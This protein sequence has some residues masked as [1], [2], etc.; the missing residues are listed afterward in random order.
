MDTNS[1]SRL[2]P[3]VDFNCTSD[4]TSVLTVTGFNNYATTDFDLDDIVVGMIVEGLDTV[5]SV[6]SVDLGNNTITVSGNVASGTYQLNTKTA[7][8]MEDAANYTGTQVNL[9]FK[10]STSIQ[11]TAYSRLF[12]QAETGSSFIYEE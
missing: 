11:A 6:Q 7:I 12:L 8:Q 4:G 5:I 3:A 1:V 10:A 9:S 2:I